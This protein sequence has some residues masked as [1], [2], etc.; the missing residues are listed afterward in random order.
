V[1]LVLKPCYSEPSTKVRIAELT[2]VNV[3]EK[4]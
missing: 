1:S 3:L 2:C 4:S